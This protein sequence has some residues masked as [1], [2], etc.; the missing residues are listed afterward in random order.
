MANEF[1]TVSERDLGGLGAGRR[2]AAVRAVDDVGQSINATPEQIAALTGMDYS[3]LIEQEVPGEK[4]LGPDGVPRQVYVRTFTGTTPGYAGGTYISS[5]PIY[6]QIQ[7][8]SGAI[9]V[10]EGG[11]TLMIPIN[12]TGSQW[13]TETYVDNNT[14]GMA[15]VS[16]ATRVWGKPYS[17]TIKYTKI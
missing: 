2:I 6:G 13:H 9:T 8:I 12:L 15:T 10:I 7:I 1:D 4:W 5:L 16:G 3:K 11:T 17:V 14:I